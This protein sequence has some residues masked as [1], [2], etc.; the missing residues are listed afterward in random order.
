MFVRH[1]K[2]GRAFLAQAVHAEARCH[3]VSW[4]LTAA[5]SHLAL[6]GL[7]LGVVAEWEEESGKGDEK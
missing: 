6:Y 3:E 1:T 7:R 5:A 4:H 2:K